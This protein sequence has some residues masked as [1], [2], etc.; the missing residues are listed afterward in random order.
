MIEI[1]VQ[2]V[3]FVFAFGLLVAGIVLA[4]KGKE[5]ISIAPL[6]IAT[7]LIIIGAVGPY[8][9]KDISLKWGKGGGELNI[10][11][12]VVSEEERQ[13]AAQAGQRDI[14]PEIKQKLDQIAEDAKRRKDEERAPEDYL[15][16]AG[17]AWDEK[18]YEDGFRLAYAGLNLEPKDPRTRA[19]IYNLLGL[20][21]HGLESYSLAEKN[22]QKAI[23]IDDTYSSPHNNLGI[24]YRSQK[25]M[26]WRRRRIK[27]PWN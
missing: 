22:Y 23:E 13:I 15:V 1:A 26:T 24:L 20:I 11:R 10:T 21:N 6:S 27:R 7:V 17:E 8:T 2:I 18:K 19:A 3:L 5:R 16:L 14:P 4:F 25:S 9:L 12:R